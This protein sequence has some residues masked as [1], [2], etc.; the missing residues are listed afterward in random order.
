MSSSVASPPLE[1]EWQEPKS[2][3]LSDISFRLDRIR[4]ALAYCWSEVAVPVV[5]ISSA[6]DPAGGERRDK[7]FLL[8]RSSLESWR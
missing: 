8:T 6:K 3:Y 2:E 4:V 7:L 5:N 1:D